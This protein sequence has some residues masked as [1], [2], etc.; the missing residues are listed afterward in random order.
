MRKFN[1]PARRSKRAFPKAMYLGEKVSVCDID[2][3]DSYR[4]TY[5]I[6]KPVHGRMTSQV[7][8]RHDGLM[9]L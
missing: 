7:S 8:V 5:Y 2:G 4:H 6:V 3:V 9:A 1:I